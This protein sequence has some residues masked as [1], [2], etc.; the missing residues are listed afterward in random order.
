MVRDETSRAT[1]EAQQDPAGSEEE[2]AALAD[3]ALRIKELK[4]KAP[5]LSVE[6]IWERIKR[7]L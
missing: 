7:E 4:E 2:L 3:I 5:E 1:S 6:R